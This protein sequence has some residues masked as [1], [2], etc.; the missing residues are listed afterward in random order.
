M[1]KDENKTNNESVILG[2][3]NNDNLIVSDKPKSSTKLAN[4]DKEL[5]TRIERTNSN[6]LII[7]PEYV[8]ADDDLIEDVKA[9][10][11]EIE[12]LGVHY[13]LGIDKLDVLLNPIMPFE[14]F[15]KHNEISESALE[16]YREKKSHLF[17]FN[18]LSFHI[19]GY[20]KRFIKGIK[21]VPSNHFGG[22]A[23]CIE[24]MKAS[25]P[26]DAYLKL[27]NSRLDYDLKIKG[28]SFDEINRRLV[29][30]RAKFLELYRLKNRELTRYFGKNPLRIVCYDM[31]KKHGI[32]AVKIEVRT[33]RRHIHV[34]H[35][36]ELPNWIAS[37]EYNPFDQI[38]LLNYD[39]TSTNKRRLIEFNALANVLGA[40]F[41]KLYLNRHSNFSRDFKKV[42]FA[43]KPTNLGDVWS[44]G[45]ADLFNEEVG[46]GLK[47]SSND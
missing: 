24:L 27:K 8:Q 14:D 39:Y 30:D 15:L 22:I 41:A 10:E 6:R 33:A 34:N 13:V 20:T 9:H 2:G 17:K 43:K 18:G 16:F 4:I 36:S 12:K 29:L 42:L 46:H 47:T 38:S 44:E 5:L 35:P 1:K 25:L 7:K 40:Q 19:V 21:S 11:K 31:R 45:V 37:G 3:E 32:D 23:E 26:E 28:V